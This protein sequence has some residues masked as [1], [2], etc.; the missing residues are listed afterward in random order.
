M[1]SSNKPMSD[2][3]QATSAFFRDQAARAIQQQVRANLII[4]KKKLK[5]EEKFILN[6]EAL[7][8]NLPEDDYTSFLYEVVSK[9]DADKYT[10][11]N[12]KH[13]FFVEFL[14]K[15]LREQKINSEQLRTVYMLH[16]AMDCFK[17]ESCHQSNIVI[18]SA[19]QTT[20]LYRLEERSPFFNKETGA[21]LFAQN[22]P[23]RI[24]TVDMQNSQ[25]AYSLC[26]IIQRIKENRLLDITDFPQQLLNIY[27]EKNNEKAADVNEIKGNRK[28]LKE[29]IDAI[30]AIETKHAAKSNDIELVKLWKI[31]NENYS[32]KHID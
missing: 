26:Y 20:G 11:I 25:L 15:A 10:E 16:A 13:T 5:V 6:H 18:K 31:I 3:E 23:L 29:L 30:I 4:S 1:K 32:T 17:Q 8:K 24:Y 27:L 7:E 21:E 22:K 14:F 12:F 9:I 28:N 19:T 2:Y